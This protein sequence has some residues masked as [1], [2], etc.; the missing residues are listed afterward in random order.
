MQDH[1]QSFKRPLL[2]SQTHK[3]DSPQHSRCP[4]CCLIPLV[5]PSGAHANARV[6]GTLLKDLPWIS[7]VFV[8]LAVLIGIIVGLALSRHGEQAPVVNVNIGQFNMIA[9][10]ML[11]TWFGWGYALCCKIFYAFGINYVLCLNLGTPPIADA[12]RPERY[13]SALGVARLTAIIAL[14]QGLTLVM[15]IAAW[16]SLHFKESAVVVLLVSV[17][18]VSFLLVPRL[19]ERDARLALRSTL[20]RCLAAPFFHVLF[21]D[22][23]VGDV[24]TSSQGRFPRSFHAAPLL[25]TAPHVHFMQPPC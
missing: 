14:L 22:N 10:L 11:L 1:S 25:T 23:I 20:F 21:I 2:K 5:P 3:E 6:H 19:F 12:S 8:T 15:C 18:H 16:R 24:L 4:D 7:A 9:G 17:F 13:L